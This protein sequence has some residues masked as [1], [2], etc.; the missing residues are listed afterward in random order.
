MEFFPVGEVIAELDNFLSVSPDVDYLTFAGAGEPTLSVS[1]GQVIRFLKD[2]YPTY[3]IAVITSGS[4]MDDHRVRNDLLQADVILPTLS[5]VF[6]E[7]FR[8]IHR[9]C[10]RVSIGEIVEG[11]VRFREEYAGQIWLEI[12]IIPGMN[13]TEK[14]L[15]ALREA[16][17]RIHPDRVQL[18][19]LDRPGTEDWVLPAEQDEMERI[20]ILLGLPVVE[21]IGPEHYS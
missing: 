9:P 21:V 12:F 11:M 8:K 20:R 17:L 4:L 3:H 14:E 19:T 7:T 10:P 13:T 2:K 15:T 16:I 1:I 5:T 18:N 6:E